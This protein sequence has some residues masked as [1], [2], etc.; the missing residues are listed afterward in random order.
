MVNQNEKHFCK[1][2]ISIHFFTNKALCIVLS[3]E[4]PT[5]GKNESLLTM[6]ILETY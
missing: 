4:L 2:L 5:S 6:F 3:L 1:I